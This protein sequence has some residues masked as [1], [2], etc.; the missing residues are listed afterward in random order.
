MS[1]PEQAKS[2]IAVNL[3]VAR[4][5]FYELLVKRK[6]RGKF[7]SVKQHLCPGPGLRRRLARVLTRRDRQKQ[8]N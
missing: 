1:L 4:K 6:F 3:S 2:E 7:L 5:L 8:E